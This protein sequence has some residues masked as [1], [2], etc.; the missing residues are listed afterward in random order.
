MSSSF[1]S[2]PSSSC[3]YNY[4]AYF[5]NGTVYTGSSPLNLAS[6]SGIL[7][8]TSNVEFSYSLYI[9]VST[10][11]LMSPL[12]SNTITFAVKQSCGPSSTVISASS[13]FKTVNTIFINGKQLNVTYSNFRS[14]VLACKI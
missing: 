6:S 7:T 8:I 2:S 14:S 4:T 13:G 11:E 5:S 10:V 1:V 12:T 3:T 9:I